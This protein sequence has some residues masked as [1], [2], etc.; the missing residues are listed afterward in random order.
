MGAVGASAAL[1]VS[2]LVT[3]ALPH[4]GGDVGLS[5]ARCGRLSCRRT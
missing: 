2:E 1:V 3:N 5:L 4:A